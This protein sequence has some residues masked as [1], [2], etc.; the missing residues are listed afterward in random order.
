V[1]RLGTVLVVETRVAGSRSVTE[2]LNCVQLRVSSRDRSAGGFEGK[3]TKFDA[4][5]N[6]HWNHD[7]K[8]TAPGM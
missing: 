1:L 3:G 2:Q 4:S 8:L 5:K 6:I 7:N